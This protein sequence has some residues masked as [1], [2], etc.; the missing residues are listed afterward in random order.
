MLKCRWKKYRSIFDDRIPQ[1][2]NQTAD[3][4]VQYEKHECGNQAKER[5]RGK[6]YNDCLRD[7]RFLV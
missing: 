7:D 2:P 1:M 3:S 4:T 6:T 5:L